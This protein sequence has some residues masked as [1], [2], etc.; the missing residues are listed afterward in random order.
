M[1]K[2][3]KAIVGG[4]GG[5]PSKGE[6][7]AAEK[8]AAEANLKAQQEAQAL[9][10]NF[11]A[12]LSTDNIAQ[13]APGGEANATGMDDDFTPRRKRNKVGGLSTQLGIGGDTWL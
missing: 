9:Q 11:R 13:I 12:D 2:I 6:A 1:K 5:G 7:E 10:E 8:A 3:F 4:G